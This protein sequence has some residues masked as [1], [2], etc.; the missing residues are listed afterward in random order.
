MWELVI[1]ATQA[2]S[3][4]VEQVVYEITTLGGVYM[5]EFFK[6]SL[7]MLIDFIMSGICA[8]FLFKKLFED[9]GNGT[10]AIGEA[11]LNWI[12]AIVSFLIM[13]FGIG[14]FLYWLMFILEINIW[15]LVIA[16]LVGFVSFVIYLFRYR[17]LDYFQKLI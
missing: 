11:L 1:N 9:V 13:L 10:G 7:L 6:F 4:A 14:M 15:Y 17:I 3:A 5:K 12:I 2:I 8:R 16:V